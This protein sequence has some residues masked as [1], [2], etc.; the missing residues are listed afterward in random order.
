MLCGKLLV[1]ETV[2]IV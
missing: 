2:H 1:E